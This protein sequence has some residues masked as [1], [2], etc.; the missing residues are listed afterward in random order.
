MIRIPRGWLFCASQVQRRCCIRAIWLV[1]VV[2]S[3]P[4]GFSWLQCAL[5][6]CNATASLPHCS[7]IAP[8]KLFCC[9]SESAYNRGMLLK[10]LGGLTLVGVNFKRQKPMLLL[11]YLAVEGAKDRRFLAELLW[12]GAK[13]ARNSLSTA[14]SQ[15]RVAAPGVVGA[16]E[17]RAWCGVDCDAKTLLDLADTGDMKGV[18]KLYQGSFLEGVTLTDIGVE[19]E[20]WIYST[21]EYLASQA[22]RAL[23]RLGEDA[24]AMGEF[25]IAGKYAERSYRLP[26]APPADPEELEHLYAML[27]AGENIHAAELRTEAEAFGLSFTVTF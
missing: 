8:A 18:L 1:G 27:V 13:D 6:G 14:L 10:T 4:P 20:E 7:L 23:L 9:P 2:K 26:D 15:L 11:A 21:R 25:R 5:G 3:I 17:V 19:L 16:D 22:R 24:A 12:M